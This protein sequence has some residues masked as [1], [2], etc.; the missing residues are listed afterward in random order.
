MSDRAMSFWVCP[1]GYFLETNSYYNG[2]LWDYTNW[3]R[4]T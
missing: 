1:D 4:Y 2:N 3:R